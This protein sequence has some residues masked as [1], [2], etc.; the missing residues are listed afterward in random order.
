MMDMVRSQI[1]LTE[2]Q[3]EA[4]RELSSATGKSMAELVRESVDQ[5]LAER[6]RPN[7]QERLQ[8]ALRVAGAFRS[9]TADG[10]SDHDRHVAEAFKV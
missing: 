6:P 10:S 5:F 3:Q 8:R 2:R 4:L 7:R 9:G 1:Q